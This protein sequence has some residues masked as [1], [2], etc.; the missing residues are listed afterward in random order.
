MPLLTTSDYIT[1]AGSIAT[2]VAAV[3]A[4]V[5]LIY[6]RGQINEAQKQ[7]R[8]SRAIAHGD[9]LLRL[10][11]AFQRHTK[12]H[13]LLQPD[14][15]WGRNK[16]GPAS[17]E[18]WFLVTSYMGLFERVNFLIESE[19]EELAIIDRLYGYRV[20]NI[21][22][23]DIIRITKLENKELARSWEGF[24][25]LWLQLK[26]LRPNWNDYPKVERPRS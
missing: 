12:V 1:L 24:I 22:A 26:S 13:M 25:Q 18:D 20:Y 7:L 9:F 5:A 19:I 8:H 23:N 2:A 10:D 15:E 11:E 17:A 3:A 14:F 21:V 4:V 6:A 16:S